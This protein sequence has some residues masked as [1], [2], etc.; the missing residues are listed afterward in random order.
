M[1]GLSFL[2]GK[3]ESKETTKGP[4]GREVKF[5]LKGTNTLTLEGKCL[6]IDETFEVEGRMFA[7]HILLTHDRGLGK[8]RAWWFSASNPARPLQFTGDRQDGKFI[9]TSD[10]SRMRIT[11]NLKKEGEY[12]AF[13]DLKRG[14]TWE[15]VTTADYRRISP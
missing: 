13:V 4:D 7:N 9:L 3:W 6:Q 15:T 14:E 2:L 8:Y 11:Y 1:K 5:D 10:D 12:H